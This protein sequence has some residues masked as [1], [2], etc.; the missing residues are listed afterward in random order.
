VGLRHLL[1]PRGERSA[2]SIERGTGSIGLGL[3][4]ARVRQHLIGSSTVGIDL[5]LHLEN[6]FPQPVEARGLVAQLL[7]NCL[8]AGRIQHRIDQRRHIV[9]R[10]GAWQNDA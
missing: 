6:F 5:L 3:Q 2:V 9:E 7:Q 8:R 4:S 1:L 10:V